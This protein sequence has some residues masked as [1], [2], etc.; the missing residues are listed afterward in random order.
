MPAK[1]KVLCALLYVSFATM[2]PAHGADQAPAL[3]SSDQVIPSLHN[4]HHVTAG[5]MLTTEEVN[6]K[7]KNPDREAPHPEMASC[8]YWEK[9]SWKAYH[10]INT[11]Y[12]ED[13]RSFELDIR[14]LKQTKFDVLK[15]PA[16]KEIYLC[17]STRRGITLFDPESQVHLRIIRGFGWN[18][19]DYITHK[20][21]DQSKAYGYSTYDMVMRNNGLTV[22][23]EIEIDRLVQNFVS[24][25]Y[26]P[27]P[28]RKKFIEMTNARFRS[29]QLLSDFAGNALYAQ[30]G[31]R[32]G[33]ATGSYHLKLL[34]SLHAD[35][36][37]IYNE[38]AFAY[39]T[40]PEP[41]SR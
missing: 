2:N 28:E 29:C 27:E 39:S 14:D 16:R 4:E 10:D 34:Q 6:L 32:A 9:V 40:P 5:N 21:E 18:I 11:S 37:E 22:I 26:L 24:L 41:G 15:W 7:F 17:Y 3:H 20:I 38:A 19:L 13:N 36:A 30:G 23:W 12:L 35:L 31:T 1:Y 33:P 25:K 8:L